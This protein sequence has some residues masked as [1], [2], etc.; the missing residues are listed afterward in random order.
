[1]PLLHDAATTQNAVGARRSSSQ[2]NSSQTMLDS[3]AGLL[4]VSR[5]LAGQC[6]GKWLHWWTDGGPLS[7]RWHL[8]VS[9]TI[10][11]RKPRRVARRS[12]P[13]QSDPVVPRR[14]PP[15]LW[16]Q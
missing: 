14:R 10:V 8:T 3:N 15:P 11:R 6:T 16:R 4:A 9:A 12:T 1:V 2:S 7:H 5:F 13:G